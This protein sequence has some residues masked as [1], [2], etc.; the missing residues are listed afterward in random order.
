ML[1]PY[2]PGSYLQ[3]RYAQCRYVIN[4]HHQHPRLLGLIN[5]SR[6]D[7]PY[8]FTL[9]LVSNF[10]WLCAL[11]IEPPIVQLAHL[12]LAAAD[13]VGDNHISV[14][15]LD[16]F[17]THT[18]LLALSESIIF[19]NVQTHLNILLHRKAHVNKHCAYVHCHS[20]KTVL[21]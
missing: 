21:I 3:H 20:A 18:C 14:T 11:S 16:A 17:A 5:F 7:E 15:P 19:L 12:D 8:F 9:T 6:H 2:T 1:C 4:W 13:L 10:S